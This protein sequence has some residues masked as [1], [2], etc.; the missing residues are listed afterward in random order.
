LDVEQLP[1]LSP[2][3]EQLACRHAGLRHADGDE[4]AVIKAAEEL[5]VASTEQLPDGQQGRG[6]LLV[7]LLFWSAQKHWVKKFH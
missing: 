3:T 2:A 1:A 5:P 6:R 7:F 4:E